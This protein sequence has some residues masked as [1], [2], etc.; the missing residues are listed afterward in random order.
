MLK[1]QKNRKKP[2][3]LIFT[4][5]I[6]ILFS[7]SAFAAPIYTITATSGANGKIE[8]EGEIAMEENEEPSFQMIPDPGY[9]VEDVVVDGMSIGS[10]SG[11]DLLPVTADHT[12][13]VTFKKDPSV[14]QYTITA[15]SGENGSI[16]PEGGVL[17][18]QG[19]DQEFSFTPG[20]GYMVSDVLVDNS[21]K[22]EI[23]SYTFEDVNDDHRIH[24]VFKA[25]PTIEY[26]ITA[27]SGSNGS[28][29]PEGI[30]T[31]AKG[32]GKSFTM[33]PA[34]GYI[35]DDVVVNSQSVGAK[36]SYTFSNVNADTTIHVTFKQESTEPE[37]VTIKG[38]ILSGET[39]LCAMVL[40]NGQYT[41]TCGENEGKY[42]LYVPLNDEGKILLYGFVEGFAPFGETLSKE[43]AANFDIN[44]VV[45]SADSVNMTI[46]HQISTSEKDPAWYKISGT[47]KYGDIDLC[48][49]VLANGQYMFTCG[50]NE[51]KYELDVP[52]NTNGEIVLYGFVE[53][54]QPY[55]ETLKPGK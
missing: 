20:S 6:L 16:N 44:M 41:F 7:Y 37:W 15:S 10:I 24:V 14:M 23:S 38:S 35:V 25:V 32:G 47:V 53:G 33:V 11:L 54:F 46:T 26:N 51:G 19:S 39:P 5:G 52:L 12:I 8:P 22:G 30:I 48:A 43:E 2:Y 21:S 55:S 13:H 28:I 45:A 18:D 42:E 9:V 17:V 4:L 49:M 50:E 29:N 3:V 36:D 34:S 31:V 1:S 40:A 27:S